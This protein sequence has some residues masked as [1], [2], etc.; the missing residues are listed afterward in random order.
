MIKVICRIVRFQHIFLNKFLS[1]LVL[2]ARKNYFM[3]VSL[4]FL[5]KSCL[6]DRL[7]T[8]VCTVNNDW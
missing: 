4:T 1:G 3:K 6:K 7:R 2:D 8:L 5:K